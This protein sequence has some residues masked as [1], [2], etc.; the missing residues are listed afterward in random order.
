MH[1]FHIFLKQLTVYG[2]IG[3][4]LDFTMFLTIIH[5]FYK[6][7]SDLKWHK[8]SFLVLGT[9]NLSAASCESNMCLF[10]D[11]QKGKQ[12]KLKCNVVLFY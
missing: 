7:Y 5:A 2:C 10:R 9:L 3:K 8:I 6:H 4:S 12:L 1:C 11:N